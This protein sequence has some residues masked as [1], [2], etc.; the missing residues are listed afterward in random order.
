VA[1]GKPDEK[2]LKGC[3]DLGKRVAVL[4]KKLGL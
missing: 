1:I 2:S 4:V 3:R